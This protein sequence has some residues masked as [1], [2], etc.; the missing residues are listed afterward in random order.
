ME[1]KLVVRG[2]PATRFF[3]VG[4]GRLDVEV[5]GKRGEPLGP[6]D[7]FDPV[8]GPAATSGRTSSVSLGREL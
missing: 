3:I 6:G 5:D 1:R 7:F 8:P 2:S 4:E